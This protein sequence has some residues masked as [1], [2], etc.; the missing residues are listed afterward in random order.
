MHI[1]NFRDEPKIRFL[2]DPWDLFEDGQLILETT[3][4][5]QARLNLRLH[6][7]AKNRSNRDTGFDAIQIRNNTEGHEDGPSP[8]YVQGKGKTLANLDVNPSVT[9]GKDKAQFDQVTSSS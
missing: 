6:Q 7:H 8:T 5:Y 9:V 4:T 2:A 3:K 1:S